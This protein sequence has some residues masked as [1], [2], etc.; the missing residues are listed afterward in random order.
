MQNIDSDL[1]RGNIDTIILKTMLGGD[2]YGLDIIREVENKS[3]GTYELKQPTLYSCL[4]RLENQELIS[5]Y[6]LDSEIGGRRHYYKLTDKGRETIKS[7]QEEWSKSKFIIDNLLG[8]FN[9]EE[10]RLVKKDDYEKIIEGKPVIQYIE[11]PVEVIKEVPV[12]VVKEV[13]VATEQISLDESNDDS[14][15]EET[16]EENSSEK[17]ENSP[18][19]PEPEEI[20]TTIEDYWQHID[21]VLNSKTETENKKE[22]LIDFNKNEHDEIANSKSAKEPIDEKMEIASFFEERS[23]KPKTFKIDGQSYVQQNLFTDTVMPYQNEVDNSIFEFTNNVS[24]LNNFD[25]SDETKKEELKKKKEIE[26]KT[27]K[28]ETENESISNQAESKLENNYESSTVH[29]EKL[30]YGILSELDALNNKN[31]L[32]FD[33]NNYSK[34]ENNYVNFEN[35]EEKTANLTEKY[36]NFSENFAFTSN[37]DYSSQESSAASNTQDYVNY[38][39]SKSENEPSTSDFLFDNQEPEAFF[40]FTSTAFT[41]TNENEPYK[42]KLQS[43]NE[44]SKNSINFNQQ[45]MPVTTD[46]KGIGDLKKEFESEGIKLKQYNKIEKRP[47]EKPYLLINKMNLIKSVILFFVFAFILSATYIIMKNTSLKEMHDFSLNMFVYG[48]IPFLAYVIFYLV[49]YSI[50]SKKK[51]AAKFSPRISMFFAIIITIQLILIIYC[52]NL[53]FGFY[54]FSQQGYNH[55][56]W[57]VPAIVSIA[58][59]VNTIIHIAL[60]NSKN[61]NV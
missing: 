16:E 52:I 47:A 11:V 9:S 55:L 6:W 46:T 2:M 13:P 35:N 43:L 1:I 21:N 22:N 42:K 33:E 54:S 3:N 26:E 4:K 37:N 57:I 17:Q 51:V 39:Y 7:K 12:E 20:I 38:S 61:F 41:P 29:A 58:P 60:Y 5:S 14:I 15:Q 23:P 45:I 32:N 49:L 48:M 27:E 18:E 44:Y 19:S 59:I 50:N 40:E 30:D 36:D 53:Q 31:E 56:L 34:T 25:Y 10:Y 8:D 24:K 28:T